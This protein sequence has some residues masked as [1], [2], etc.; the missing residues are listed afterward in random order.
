MLKA[1]FGLKNRFDVPASKF[2]EHI[3]TRD[4][5][6]F[7]SAETIALAVA[8]V[9][10]AGAAYFYF[11]TNIDGWFDKITDVFDGLV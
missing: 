2:V 3:E 4:D 7:A 6:G 9:L 1:Y 8:G 5:D 11:D 10:I